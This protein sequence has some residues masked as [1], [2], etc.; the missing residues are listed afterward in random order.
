MLIPI[1]SKVLINILFHVLLTKTNDMYK[2]GVHYFYSTSDFSSLDVDYIMNNNL[3]IINNSLLNANQHVI[4]QVVNCKGVM[5]AGIAKSI[6]TAAPNV[7]TA[8][9][10]IC[11]TAPS[12]TSLLGRVQAVPTVNHTV[13]NFFAQD[14]YGRDKRYLDYKAFTTCCKKLNT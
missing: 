7:F 3:H 9:K 10:A 4:V 2:G 14:A 1:I 11:D 13:I 6:R 12:S 8:Y 5:G